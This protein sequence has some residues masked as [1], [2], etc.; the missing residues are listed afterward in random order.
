[1]V[2]RMTLPTL[3]AIL[4]ACHGNDTTH[5]KGKMVRPAAP[6][7]SE[8]DL[9]EQL[10]D[11]RKQLLKFGLE[12]ARKYGWLKY[13]FG[14]ADPANGGFDC[15]GAVFYM[16]KSI[17]MQPPRTSSAQY[18]WVRDA[19]NLVPVTRDISSLDDPIFQQLTPGDLLF[20]SGTYQPTDGRQTK[21]THVAIFAG[22]DASGKPV[23]LNAS[24]GRSYRGKSQNGFGLFDFK[25][26][27]KSAKS[28]FL[29]FG[30]PPGLQ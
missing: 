7:F 11:R 29:G 30:S 1:M 16:L 5:A 25:L 28:K 13:M 6:A 24:S 27:R 23:M 9:P 22:K 21:V 10:S 8:L 20:W 18:L 15:S 17:G 2:T 19:G 4:L 26:P 3:L 14:S 12:T